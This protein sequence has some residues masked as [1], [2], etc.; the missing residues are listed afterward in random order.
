MFSIIFLLQDNSIK[1][2]S[3]FYIA[4][5]IVTM[6]TFVTHIPN[7][8]GGNLSPSSSQ[9]HSTPPPPPIKVVL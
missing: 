8:W 4:L 6:T 9:T 2:T 1:T 5:N 7:L 3:D